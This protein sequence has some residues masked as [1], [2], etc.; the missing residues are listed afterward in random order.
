MPKA[1]SKSRPRSKSTLLSP[2][3]L[4]PGQE[5]VRFLGLHGMPTWVKCALVD[6]LERGAKP[7][8]YEI[9][10]GDELEAKTIDKLFFLVGDL[11]RLPEP[12]APKPIKKR[13]ER[14]ELQ[15]AK[16]QLEVLD[17]VPENEA[18][19]LQLETKIFNLEH[20]S[21]DEEWPDVIE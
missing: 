12:D 9:I 21:A 4:R 16:D 18:Y 8:N 7:H 19:R 14:S 17:F 2:K 6:A 15:K 11:M 10:R 3:P 20:E 13:K 1:N 5:I